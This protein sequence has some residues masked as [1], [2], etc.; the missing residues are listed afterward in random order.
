MI[1]PT[2]LPG[3]EVALR[4]EA[5]DRLAFPP[6]EEAVILV[7]VHKAGLLAPTSPHTQLM[8]FSG[9]ELSCTQIN[10]EKAPRAILAFWNQASP[11]VSICSCQACRRS[12]SHWLMVSGSKG[13]GGSAATASVRIPAQ[14]REKIADE[15]PSATTPIPRDWSIAYESSYC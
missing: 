9:G 15:T 13:S 7:A 10:V 14:A 5:L 6:P 12:C 2:L 4:P 3:T 11:V 8:G 1:M